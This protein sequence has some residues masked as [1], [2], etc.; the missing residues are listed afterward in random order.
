MKKAVAGIFIIKC[1]TGYM[2]YLY[3]NG[4]AWARDIK[5][6]RRFDSQEA[7][8]KELRSLS[9]PRNCEAGRVPECFQFGM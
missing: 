1:N 8:D 9:P 4:V 2:Q 7:G 3:W 6:A 5:G